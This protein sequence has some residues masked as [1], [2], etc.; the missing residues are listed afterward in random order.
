MTLSE[1]NSQLKTL[2]ERF[3]SLIRRDP[4]SKPTPGAQ[5]EFQADEIVQ[6][7]RIHATLIVV[8][9]HMQRCTWLGAKC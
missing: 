9:I 4:A 5:T 8:H 2:C 1:L 6:S 7:I 3:E